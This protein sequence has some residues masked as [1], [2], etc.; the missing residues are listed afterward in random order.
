MDKF[1]DSC[2]STNRRQINT[3]RHQEYFIF[4]RLKWLGLRKGPF[5]WWLIVT[6]SSG[7]ANLYMIWSL[8][9]F[10]SL[11]LRFF[12]LVMGLWLVSNRSWST[13]PKPP[14]RSGRCTLGQQMEKRGSSWYIFLEWDALSWLWICSLH[15]PI[16]KFKPT[17]LYVIFITITT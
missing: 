11:F 2:I 4:H 17:S 7:W 3:E 8:I 6:D 15:L 12:R 13:C 14:R 9:R 1:R 16:K 5:I 10:H